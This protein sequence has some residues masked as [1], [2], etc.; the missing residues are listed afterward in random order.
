MAADSGCWMP[1]RGGLMLTGLEGESCR[2][3]S[4]CWRRGMGLL[5]ENS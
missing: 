1:G 4:G 5:E 3:I 2:R